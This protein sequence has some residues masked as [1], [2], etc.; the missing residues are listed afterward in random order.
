[1]GH[2][3]RIHCLSASQNGRYAKGNNIGLA[4]AKNKLKCEFIC[5][6]NPDTIIRNTKFIY[7]FLNEYSKY[8]YA[9][10][11]PKIL[12][13]GSNCNPLRGYSESIWFQIYHIIEN[14]RIYF[15]KKFRLSRFRIKKGQVMDA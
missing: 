7:T 6:L 9:V 11:G 5:V 3:D 10:C 15:V 13:N 2:N 14:Y 8:H 4:Y 1:M 12:C